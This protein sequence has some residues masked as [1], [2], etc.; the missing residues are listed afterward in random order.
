MKSY[1]QLMG[2]LTTN[3]T[4]NPKLFNADE[5]MNGTIRNLIIDRARS[6]VQKLGLPADSIEDVRL[7]GGNAG[8]NYSNDSSDLDVTIMLDRT[9]NLSKEEIRRLGRSSNYLTY[10]LSPSLDGIPL[11]F[12]VSSRNLGGLRPAQQTVYS[13]F[14]NRF[15]LGPT[16]FS[17]SAP[18]YIASKAADIIQAIE[19][20]CDDDDGDADDCAQKLYTRLR[21]YRI[22]GLKS[23]E[24]E[25]STPA[26]VWRVLSRSGYIQMLK[27]K[28]EQLEKEYYQLK[29]P[30]P[31]MGMK[32][33]DYKMLIA[34]THGQY[35]Y[36]IAKW[37]KRILLGADPSKLI[38]RMRPIL[39]LILKEDDGVFI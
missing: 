34:G 7:T 20:C 31:T 24:G 30:N 2:V 32:S 18:N 4:L 33:E 38:Q 12:F 6:Y 10:K 15:L 36:A 9:M 11:N 14:Q 16:K 3:D 13:I 28:I 21:N 35:P 37:S 19:S 27:D 22:S 23:K 26:L 17:E 8:Y 25:N 39:D 5:S 1:N 29:S